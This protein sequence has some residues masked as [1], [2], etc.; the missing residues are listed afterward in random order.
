MRPSMAFTLKGDTLLIAHGQGP[1]DDATFDKLVTTAV[2]QFRLTRFSRTIAVSAGGAPT[3]AQRHR[4]DM[5]VR[6][7]IVAKLGEPH[8]R[9][10]VVTAS[11][12]TRAVV[13][14]STVFEDN[15]FV[16]KVGRGPSRIYRA[17]PPE[18]LMQAIAW[19]NVPAE[20]TPLIL[21]EL[22][23]LRQEVE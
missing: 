14:A 18:E 2:E 6:E 15:W 23:K 21:H 19:L 5:R 22:Q 8:S 13:T 16:R 20:N 9:M 10:A 4:L 17:F 3:A 1:P 12:F 7:E 11:T